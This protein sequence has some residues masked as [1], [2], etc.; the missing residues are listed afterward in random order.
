MR[1]GIRFW[2]KAEDVGNE[3]SLG[4][5]CIMAVLGDLGYLRVK[6][7]KAAKWF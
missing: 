5:I 6:D 3:M 7:W 2:I 1:D 4:D